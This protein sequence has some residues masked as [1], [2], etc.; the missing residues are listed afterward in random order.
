MIS[1][2]LFVCLFV[3]VKGVFVCFVVYGCMILLYV[4]LFVDVFALTRGTLW[5]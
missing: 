1:V 3:G 5:E 4:C 2:L